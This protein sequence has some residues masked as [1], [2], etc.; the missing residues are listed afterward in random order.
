MGWFVHGSLA[1]GSCFF[2]S[3]LA[4]GAGSEFAGGGC[5]EDGASGMLCGCDWDA[6]DWDA[7]DWDACD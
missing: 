3:G 1:T 4:G 7:C 6:C 2:S 5:T